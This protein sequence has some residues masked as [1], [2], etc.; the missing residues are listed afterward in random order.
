[1]Q[2]NLVLKTFLNR[3]L[4]FFEH[5]THIYFIIVP[6]YLP[7]YLVSVYKVVAYWLVGWAD[8]FTRNVFCITFG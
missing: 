3:I 2:Q 1:M 5:D 7:F 6:G 8:W 4:F